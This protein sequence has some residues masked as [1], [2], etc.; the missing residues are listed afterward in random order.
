[1]AN[2]RTDYSKESTKSK[3]SGIRFDLEKLELVQSREKLNTKQKVV[4]FLLNRYW[5]EHKLP[6]PTHKEVPP[7][8]RKGEAEFKAHIAEV[9]KQTQKDKTVQEWINEKRELETPEQFEA[10]CEALAASTLSTKQKKMVEL[11]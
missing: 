6:V 8:D 2:N 7:I 5:W 9:V 4:D 1:M 11:A 3:P 10:F